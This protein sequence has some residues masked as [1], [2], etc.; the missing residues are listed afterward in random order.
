[1]NFA[2]RYGSVTHPSDVTVYANTKI[3]GQNRHY[4]AILIVINFCYL[5]AMYFFAAIGILNSGQ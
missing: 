3:V 4:N 1:M 2:G 5:Q